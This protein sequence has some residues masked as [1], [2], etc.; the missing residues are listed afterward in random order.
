MT[1]LKQKKLFHWVFGAVIITALVVFFGALYFN[2][3]AWGTW[4]D[5]SAGYIYLAGRMIQG[6]PLVYQDPLAKLGLEFFGDEKLARWLTPTH[7]E[8]INQQGWLASK[9]PVGASMLLAGAAWL[10]GDSAGFY[11]VIPA[12]AVLN[13]VL[14]YLLAVTLF[15]K[16][17][18]RHLIGLVSALLLGFSNLYYTYALSQPMREIPSTAFLLT[19]FLTLAMAVRALK[20]RQQRRWQAVGWLVVS[21]AAM[22][23]AF[24]IRE[25]SLVVLPAALA[26][27]ISALWHKNYTWRTNLRK[28][29]PYIAAFFVVFVLAAIP[30]INNSI[31][32]S[33]E[34]EVFKKRDRSEIVLLSNIN[35]I[36]TI[37]VK[38]LFANDGKFRPGKGSLPHYW[39]IMQKATPLPYFLV[40]VLV[41]L[42]YLWR[43]SRPTAALLFLWPLAILTI[44]S[45]WINP[46]SRYILP[47]FP[48]LML[49]GT[50][51]LVQVLTDGL[52]RLFSIRWQ[53]RLVGAVVVGGLLLSYQATLAEVRENFTTEVY[54]N[55]AISEQDLITLRQIT[56]TIPATENNVLMLS[57]DWQYGFSEMIEAHTGL[58]SI[59]YPLEQRFDFD[60]QQ[61]EQFF[62]EMLAA[63]YDLY[64]WADSSSSIRLH[65]WLDGQ[66]KEEVLVQDYSFQPDVRFYRIL[67]NQQ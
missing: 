51:G 23:M 43:E 64:V 32:I 1:D 39:Q 12:L 44:F 56:D 35:H 49:V 10:A 52:P 65:L 7:H 47:L 13:L 6:Q 53:H 21:A 9:Y 14:T 15:A 5:D 57:G 60:E 38:N 42:V 46:Y 24:N 54:R 22:G 62:S 55:K 31:S 18:W 29:M 16:H 28:V 66:N 34:K 58:K 33:A 40:L 4:G 48:A 45:L 59:R 19:T 37:S 27:A 30:T 20:H 8:F 50:Y 36:Q 17:R 2:D 26:Y 61:V 67:S 25:T 63:G 11:F 41:G 3:R